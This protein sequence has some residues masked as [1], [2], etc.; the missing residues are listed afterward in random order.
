MRRIAMVALGL[1]T[2]AGAT[3]AQTG[4]GQVSLAIGTQA[5]DVELQDLDENDVSLLALAE[6]KP[7]LIEFWAS[8]CEQCEALQPQLDTIHETYGDQV[9][10]VAVA[11][12]VSQTLRR[13][14]RHVEDAGHGYAFL[15]DGKGAAVRAY[16]AATTAIIVILDEEGKVAYTG[17]GPGQDL[18]AVV[19]D[20][21][22]GR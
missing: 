16:Q 2:T 4:E 7:M 19:S 10:I 11:V 8:W 17:V 1:L 3:S 5:P 15:W 22:G 12:A 20:M 6:G 18:V 21:V 9:N 13:V 14:R